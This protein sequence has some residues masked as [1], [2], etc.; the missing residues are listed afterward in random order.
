MVLHHHH[1]S[2]SSSG[3]D[4]VRREFGIL[5]TDAYNPV[6]QRIIQ[7]RD[8]RCLFHKRHGKIMP[9][10][11]ERKRVFSGHSME[12]ILNKIFLQSDLL[13]ENLLKEGYEGYDSSGTQY[14]LN[15]QVTRQ[16]FMEAT[17]AQ[18]VGENKWRRRYGMGKN[19]APR[20][21]PISWWVY[22]SE[23]QY[24][25]YNPLKNEIY[26]TLDTVCVD[27]GEHMRTVRLYTVRSVGPTAVET[28]MQFGAINTRTGVIDR[29]CHSFRDA[30]FSEV[31]DPNWK[32]ANRAEEILIR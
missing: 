23:D 6:M 10:G 13:C 8:E 31:E 9:G 18:P 5:D 15:T 17:R 3:S 12:Q 7:D 24:I 16:M 4:V 14:K 1:H 2:N 28:T 11:F 29:E 21:S 22:I 32:W 25:E 27:L 19:F 20:F 26:V 30:A